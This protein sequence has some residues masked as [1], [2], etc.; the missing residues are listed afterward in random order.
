MNEAVT[1]RPVAPPAGPAARPWQEEIPESRRRSLRLWLYSIAA[2]TFAVMVVGGITRLTQSGLSIVD[3][4][5]IMGVIPPLSEAQ[6]QDA[7]D[8]Y[9]PFPEYQVLRR[10]MTMDEF[11]FIFFWE[12]LHRVLARVIGLVFLVPFIWFAVRRYFNRELAVRALALFGLGAM[13]GV[14]GWLMVSSGLVDRPSVSHFRLAAHLSLAFIIFGACIWLA[15]QL[16]PD[17]SPVRLAP[18]VLRGLRIGA[19]VVG[20]LLALQIVWGAFVAG[21]KAGFMYNTF[22]LMGGRLVPPDLFALDGTVINFFQ[23][24][25]AVQ[26][27]HR[28]LGTV[29]T[30][31]A[32][33]VG[34]RALEAR[35]DAVSRRLAVGIM[36]LMLIQYA[37]GILTLIYRVPVSL[38]VAHQGL[39]MVIFGVWIWWV[40]HLWKVS[41]A[42][43]SASAAAPRSSIMAAR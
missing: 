13:Q 34:I 8:R 19:V 41:S 38:G 18:E 27:V 21:L 2:T 7:F 12:Y 35:V 37:L 25:S 24:S 30:L 33:G 11:K 40:H 3:W 14:L 6:W 43:P 42:D 26:W 4:Q 36:A 31:A 23:H 16:R 22:P 1:S 20:V 10:G 32:V 39:A 5:P 29:L 17:F 15:R 28:V 9:R